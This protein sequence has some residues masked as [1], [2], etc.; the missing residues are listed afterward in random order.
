M[1]KQYQLAVLAIGLC[2]SRC[3]AQA[4]YTV[5][6]LGTLGGP[7]SLA[8]AVNN[9]GVVVGTSSTATDPDIDRAFR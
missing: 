7:S 2:A 8:I 5:V 3:V 4:T 6:D 1:P 9:S